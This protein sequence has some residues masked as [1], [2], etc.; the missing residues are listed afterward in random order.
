[1]KKKTVKEEVFTFYSTEKPEELKASLVQ[2]MNKSPYFRKMIYEDLG[3]GAFSIGFQ[4]G[5]KRKYRFFVHMT[6][7]GEE[8]VINGVMKLAPDK[9]VSEFKDKPMEQ[10]A[11]YFSAIIVLLIVAVPFVFVY[12]GVAIKKLFNKKLRSSK[13][14]M[15]MDF[16]CN[17][18][19]CSLKPVESK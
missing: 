18:L 19:N 14:A 2:R 12:I 4:K 17:Y 1:M 10:L 16:M 8:T 5:G 3:E 13:V 15:L 7:D 9:D 11:L 6:R